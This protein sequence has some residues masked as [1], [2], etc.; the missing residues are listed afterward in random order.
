MA[1]PRFHLDH[2]FTKR[3][4]SAFVEG[5][6]EPRD[7]DRVHRHVD[8]CPDCGRTER[9]LRKLLAGLRLLRS[10]QPSRLADGVIARVRSANGAR[11][12]AGTR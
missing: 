1:G 3:R 12:H 7:G 11:E 2:L 4:L 5:D 6:L 9:S 8:E 10:P